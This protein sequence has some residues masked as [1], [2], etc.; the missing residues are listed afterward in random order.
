M[1]ERDDF[2]SHEKYEADNELLCQI[3]RRV[4]E[5][6]ERAALA[7]SG[8][9]QDDGGY[10]FDIEP[11]ARLVTYDDVPSLGSVTIIP[12]ESL[13][14]P[15]ERALVMLIDTPSNDM[16]DATR[17]YTLLFHRRSRDLQRI[18]IGDRILTKDDNGQDVDLL[19]AMRQRMANGED[20]LASGDDLVAI[21]ALVDNLKPHITSHSELM[22]IVMKDIFGEDIF[23][24]D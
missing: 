5:K 17:Y 1:S 2:D 12:E 6:M 19:D 20:A 16:D 11:L 24:D 8:T 15:N 18:F 14:E 7:Q 3:G 21:S 9:L 10:H 23:L 13:G 22:A 4:Q